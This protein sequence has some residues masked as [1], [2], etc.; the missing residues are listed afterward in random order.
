MKIGTVKEIAYKS[1]LLGG[2][3]ELGEHGIWVFGGL[4]VVPAVGFILG[5]VAMLAGWSWWQFLLLVVTPLSL[6]LT[7][8]DLRV[9]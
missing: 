7:I 2:R 9:A 8:L 5:A 3:W 4:W 1:T 6:L